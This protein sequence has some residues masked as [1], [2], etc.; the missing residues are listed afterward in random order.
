VTPRAGRL[1]AC[2]LAVF[3]S[4]SSCATAQA[5]GGVPDQSPADGAAARTAGA[6][7]D[8]QRDL[9]RARALA[10]AHERPLLV[11]INVDGESSSE[12]I[13]VERYRDP[14]FVAATRGFVCVLGSPVRHN[15][16]DADEF[17]RRIECPR[18]G[19]VTCGE[20]IALEPAI[21]DAFLAEPRVS[22]RHALIG[23]DGAKRFDLYYLFDMRELDRALLAAGRDLEPWPQARVE[24]ADLAR[25]DLVAWR[26][27]A[28]DQSARACA[29][30]L[31][32]F[33]ALSDEAG[34]RNALRAASESDPALA[35]ELCVAAIGRPGASRVLLFDAFRRAREAQRLP[36]LCAWGRWLRESA[37]VRRAAEGLLVHAPELARPWSE[38]QLTLD[39]L[40]AR[41]WADD[42]AGR[43]W[44][45]AILACGDAARRAAVERGL[46]AGL[47]E[48]RMA[49]LRDAVRVQGGPI[50]LVA[51]LQ[52]SRLWSC[53]DLP[54]AESSTAPG[55]SDPARDL[56][57]A[58]AA[59]DVAPDDPRAMARL[60]SASLALARRRLESAQ[61]GADLLLRD[62]QAWYARA[63]AAGADFLA[64]SA[65]R[66]RVAYLL[67]DF[68]EQ[69][70]IAAEA[71]R[72]R[73]PA[74]APRGARLRGWLSATGGDFVLAA[75]DAA[76]AED[77]RWLADAGLRR[78]ISAP[79][80]GSEAA[81]AL[82]PRD[83]AGSI[84][85][86]LRAAAAV[87]CSSRSGESDWLTLA[88]AV[89][90][91][92]GVSAEGAVLEAAVSRLPASNALRA[93]LH[94][95][96]WRLGRVEWAVDVA[97]RVARLHP[98]AGAPDDGVALWY[99][100]SAELFHA[101]VLRRQ[102]R[103]DE[104]LAAA[105]RAARAYEAAEAHA[106]LAD[107]ARAWR[108]RSHLARAHALLQRREEVEAAEELV[109][110]ASIDAGTVAGGILGTRDG[111]DRDL[112]DAVDGVLEW[113]SG[114]ASRVDGLQLARRLDDALADDAVATQVL[115]MLAD[116]LLREALRD[117]GR[118]GAW[119]EFEHLVRDEDDPRTYWETRRGRVPTAAGDALMHQSLAV[120]RLAVAR[121]AG[122]ESARRLLAQTLSVAAQREWSRG[123]RALA[124]PRL[125][126]ASSL[127]G[128]PV[129][130]LDEA[131]GRALLHALRSELGPA[132]PAPRPGR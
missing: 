111:L 10:S 27:L 66:A 37:P 51:A 106:W 98:P 120:A 48:E 87:A 109:Q 36:E 32:A 70:R 1:A 72:A 116:A 114:R 55:A 68:G 12:R 97:R 43:T 22:P 45:L 71:L 6:Q 61:P 94:D 44:L 47:G 80:P 11:A 30:A 78:A 125:S 2:C 105:T 4:W 127:L 9:A 65:D 17:G 33:D 91:W 130:E 13:V 84:A 113:R 21:F 41:Q 124:L 14:G 42:E 23:P 129:A 100:G 122:A 110:A 108:A 112:P 50:D 25:G 38:A 18:F 96:G 26:A 126:E 60:A 34:A 119:A 117:D 77:A 104:A 85:R 54:P 76:W 63:L 90:M 88:S 39:E 75:E 31:A 107:S 118:E 52:A 74:D 132:R 24:A 58:E 101:E 46:V 40:L 92:S 83:D 29:Q 131:G 79:M 57:E 8:W 128:R 62:A 103:V 35:L 49:A 82:D 121:S 115:S 81:A 19:Q 95:A 99:L 67:G 93:A 59:L 20:H 64:L 5:G 28:A 3:V 7:I 53:M 16:R 89:R 123:E 56:A 73:Q 69:A 15:P 102:L 86:T